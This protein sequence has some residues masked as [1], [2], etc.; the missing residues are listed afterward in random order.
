[1]GFCCCKEKKNLEENDTNQGEPSI[2]KIVTEVSAQNATDTGAKS[3]ERRSSINDANKSAE[4][5]LSRIDG[6][7]QQ[8]GATPDGI[9]FD[10]DRKVNFFVMFLVR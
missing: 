8:K 1:M 9:L 10:E 5:K 3:T 6:A 2:Q 7:N 4:R